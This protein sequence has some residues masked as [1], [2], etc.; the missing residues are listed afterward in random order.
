MYTKD[1]TKE[2]IL[3][4]INNWGEETFAKTIGIHFIDIDIENET[5]TATM[6][7]TPNI[8]QPFGIMH[9]GASCVLA[10]TMGS[11][12]SN[13]FIDGSKYFGVGTNI[14]SNHLRSKKDGIVT[15]VARFIRKGKTMHVSEIE[16]RDEKDQLINHTTMTNTIIN[17]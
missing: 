10:E 12:L 6:P 3:E 13:I 11:S 17:R 8:H 7:V 5:L 2:E 1:K 4:F 14:N 15:A 16:I 9:G